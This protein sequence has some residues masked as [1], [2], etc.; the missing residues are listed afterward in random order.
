MPTLPATFGLCRR[1]GLN[2]CSGTTARLTKE[3]PAARIR[4]LDHGQSILRPLRLLKADS[5][6]PIAAASEKEERKCLG[7]FLLLYCCVDFLREL[8][9][10][11]VMRAEMITTRIK[12]AP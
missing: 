8:P 1:W 2:T 9:V 6:L 10:V 12:S 3:A 4:L 7:R 11:T 5:S